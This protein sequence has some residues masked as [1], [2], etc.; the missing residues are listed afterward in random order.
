MTNRIA[1]ILVLSLCYGAAPPARASTLSD[2]FALAQANDPVMAAARHKLGEEEERIPQAW[3]DLLPALDATAEGSKSLADYSFGSGPG[4]R[5]DHSGDW[6]VKLKQPLFDWGSWQALSVARAQTDAARIDFAQA[7]QDLILRLAQACFDLDLSRAG[8]AEI[9]AQMKAV[10]EQQL[11][12]EQGFAHGAKPVT[13]I[14]EAKVRRG[15]LRAERVT[16]LQ[17]LAKRQEGLRKILGDTAFT[18]PAL[19]PAHLPELS[20]S[21]PPERWIEAAQ[22]SGLKVLSAG[23][24]VEA[25]ASAVEKADAGDWPR[26][27]L[28]A[29]FGDSYQSSNSNSMFN[30]PTR[31][32]NNREVGLSVTL[33]LYAGGGTLSRQREARETQARLRAELDSTRGDAAEEAAVALA[34]LKEGKAA[35]EDM[36]EAVEAAEKSV[37]ANRAAALFGQK[38]SHEVFV[39]LAQA[40]QARKSRLGLYHLLLLNHLKLVASIGAL[41]EMVL[42]RLDAQLELR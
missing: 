39:A 36:T 41:D 42:A 37:A 23:K 4:P 31:A 17:E 14:L 24:A 28:N 8:L 25:A 21:D 6:S 26:V 7:R 18:L 16:V 3:A 12:A 13:D 15:Q 27:G 32:T 30:S 5:K 29:S 33:P 9:D 35:M 10:A 22:K 34:A 1:W 20:D 38:P 11:A 2:L 19:D 40:S